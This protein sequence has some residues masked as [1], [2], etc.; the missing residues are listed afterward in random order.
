M[1]GHKWPFVE[2]P[3]AVVRVS[4]FVALLIAFIAI[5]NAPAAENCLTKICPPA[6]PYH[7]R[8]LMLCCPDDY[9]PKPC[10]CMAH[11]QG[12]CPND[13]CRKPFPCLSSPTGWCGDDY[14]RKPLP[15]L[16]WPPLRTNI[17]CGR[18]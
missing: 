8:A 7:S 3:H 10:P 12:W 16:C 5:G 17:S 14:C 6:G 18:P 11:P 1:K 4:R 15:S 2:S 13:Y 9:C